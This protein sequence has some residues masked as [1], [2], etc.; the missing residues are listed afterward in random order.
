MSV[1]VLTHTR[2]PNSFPL[3]VESGS[4]KQKVNMLPEAIGIRA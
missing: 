2:K 4:K 3:C 1:V